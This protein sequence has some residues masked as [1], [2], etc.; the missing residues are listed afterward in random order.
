MRVSG[1]S[2][3][4]VGAVV[5]ATGVG[6]AARSAADAEEAAAATA[7]PSDATRL[8]FALRERVFDPSLRSGSQSDAAPR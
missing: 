8:G 4:V 5:L 7:L 6:V 2:L 3:F 1:S